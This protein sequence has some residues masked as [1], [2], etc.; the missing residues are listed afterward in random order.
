[1]PAQNRHRVTLQAEREGLMG[2]IETSPREERL[3]SSAKMLKA[4]TWVLNP[5]PIDSLKKIP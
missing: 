3:E 2:L 1:M 4:R 5:G